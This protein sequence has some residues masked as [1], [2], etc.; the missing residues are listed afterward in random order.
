[1]HQTK[2]WF[3]NNNRIKKKDEMSEERKTLWLELLKICS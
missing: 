1:M 2:K 3:S